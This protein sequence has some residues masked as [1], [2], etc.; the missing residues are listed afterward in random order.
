VTVPQLVVEWD[1]PRILV[2]SP[3]SNRFIEDAKALGGRWAPVKKAWTF[4]PR[5]ADRVRALLLTVYGVDDTGPVPTVDITAAL[6]VYGLTQGSGELALDGRTLVQRRSRDSFPVFYSGVT[7]LQ[8]PRFE[9]SGGSRK[10]PRLDGQDRSRTLLVRDVP[11]PLAARFVARYPDIYA[12]YVPEEPAPVAD[13]HE[14]EARLRERLAAIQ[15]ELASRA[16]TT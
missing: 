9:Q 7:L 4:D 5:D 14:E 8:G 15:N 12:R 13:L 6:G 10:N 1:G 16:Q 11:V 3:F 2:H